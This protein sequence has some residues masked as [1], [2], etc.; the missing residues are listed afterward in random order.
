MSAVLGAIQTKTFRFS[1]DPSEEP[2]V[3]WSRQDECW[4][5]D[6]EITY[7]WRGRTITIPK[8]YMTDLASVPFFI[9]PII[10]SY[11]NFNFAALCHDYIYGYQGVLPNGDMFSRADADR[12]LFDRMVIDGTQIRTA[13][14][15]W[16]AVRVWVGNYPCFREWK[17]MNHEDE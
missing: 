9:R 1:S 11:G 6:H 7:I 15:M 17:G 12:M 10:N 4:V 8:G 14:V 13:M 5:L 3:Y 2:R 16:L